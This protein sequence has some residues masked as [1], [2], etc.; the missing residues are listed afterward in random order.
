MGNAR[1]AA[2]SERPDDSI[3]AQEEA[4]IRTRIREQLLKRQ[5]DEH[6][7]RES[8]KQERER[9]AEIERLRWH[10]IEEETEQ[11]H[12]ALGRKKYVSSSGQVKWLTPEE[13]DARR[14]RRSRSKSKYRRRSKRVRL[15][16]VI[17]EQLRAMALSFAVSVLLLVVITLVIFAVEFI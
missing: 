3:S 12:R 7:L 11:F 1:D 15:G 2:D 10:V 6:T 13:F 5:E 14:A 9:Q 4:E 8:K 16:D 17:Q